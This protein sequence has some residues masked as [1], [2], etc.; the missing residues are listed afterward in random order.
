MLSPSFSQAAVFYLEPERAT[1]SPGES[2]VL[3]VRMDTQ[4]ECLNTVKV[5]L[6]FPNQILS[7]QDFMVG[8]SILT[9]WI[10][11]PTSD[12]VIKANETGKLSFAGGIPGGYCGRVAGDPSLTNMLGEIVFQVP[13]IIVGGELEEWKEIKILPSSQAFLNDGRGTQTVVHSQNGKVMIT[14]EPA[15]G[16]N[17]WQTML[18]ED[19]V[20]PEPFT[21]E[22]DQNPRVF[23][24]QHFLV[25]WTVDKQTGIDHFEVKEGSND[26]KEAETP[27]LLED[28]SLQSKIW[29]KAV[30][31]AGNE[32]IVEYV[33]EGYESRL[34]SEE[35]QSFP[36]WVPVLGVVLIIMGVVFTLDSKLPRLIV[37]NSSPKEEDS[38]SEQSS[39]QEKGF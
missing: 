11:Q 34:A 10:Q 37:K 7:V 30:D 28:Q 26:Y 38:S 36:W 8:N 32:R 27:Y 24:G 16:E 14:S 23:N 21:V 39:E 2:F 31:K 18:A 4:G 15:D 3:E 12:Q 17:R 5:D 9:H 25:F 29:V 20:N 13:G 6:E 22:V 35:E 19:D 33:P 1:H